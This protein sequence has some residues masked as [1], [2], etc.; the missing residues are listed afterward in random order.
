[1]AGLAL[2]WLRDNLNMIN[3]YQ[4][5]ETLAASVPNTGGVYFVPA[6]S[7]LYAPCNIQFF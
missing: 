4:E 3:N 2:R 7:G 5:C 1:V 6:F